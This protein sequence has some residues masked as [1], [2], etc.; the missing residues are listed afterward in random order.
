MKLPLTDG[1]LLG[2]PHEE[3]V[4]SIDRPTSGHQRFFPCHMYGVFVFSRAPPATSAKNFLLKFLSDL[5]PLSFNLPVYPF[6]IEARL[7]DRSSGNRTTGT[8]LQHKQWTIG[9][10]VWDQEYSRIA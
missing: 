2:G 4:L 3:L 6:I 10:E 9:Q 5:I 7:D 1:G 8:T